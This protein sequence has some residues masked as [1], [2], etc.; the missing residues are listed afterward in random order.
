MMKAV[1][2]PTAGV[3]PSD[4]KRFAGREP[5]CEL[6][7]GHVPSLPFVF[8]LVSRRRGSELMN[9]FCE[10]REKLERDFGAKIEVVETPSGGLAVAARYAF[11]TTDRT[12]DADLD[13]AVASAGFRL[14]LRSMPVTEG[15][16]EERYERFERTESPV[17]GLILTPT[18]KK[19]KKGEPVYDEVALTSTKTYVGYEQKY[20]RVYMI[21]EREYASAELGKAAQSAERLLALLSKIRPA[22]TEDLPDNVVPI[23]RAAPKAEE[24]S[25]VFGKPEAPPK[26][27]VS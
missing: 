21:S 16:F 3:R 14:T 10:A 27:E 12:I 2:L 6:A 26:S 1:R 18:G 25:G 24:K 8:D 4:E 19:D 23:S 7:T 22:C 13:Y 15:T 20:L 11:L 5:L 9:R 17:T